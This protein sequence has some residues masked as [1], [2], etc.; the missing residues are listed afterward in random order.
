[1]VHM[2]HPVRGENVPRRVRAGK[3]AAPSIRTALVRAVFL[4]PFVLGVTVAMLLRD[5]GS[6]SGVPDPVTEPVR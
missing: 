4:L 3:E 5:T 6:W 2:D 1:M